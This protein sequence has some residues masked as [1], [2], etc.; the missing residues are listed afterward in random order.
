MAVGTKVVVEIIIMAKSFAFGALRVVVIAARIANI[1]VIA[2][3][4][5]SERNFIGEEIFVALVAQ[6]VLLVK[7]MRAN[8]GTVVDKG[9]LVSIKIFLTMLAK[10]I[11]LVQAVVADVN[12][13]AVT[14]DNLPRL[15]AKVLALLAEF[16]FIRVAVVA[17]E[18]VGKFA[19]TRN[20]QPVSPDLENLE[21]IGMV[22]TNGNFGVEFGMKPVDVTAKAV[23]AHDLDSVFVAAV[24][25]GL[26]EIGNAF[27]LGNFALNQIAI[28][29]RFGLS[30]AS[31]AV[32]V[33]EP[34]LK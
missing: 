26:P 6:Q 9:H 1:D 32:S 8:I 7:A 34:T 14:I 22:L 29:F 25:F 19:G 2:I 15:G 31:S 28:K 18:P 30:P 33:V 11:V 20:A 24:F 17:D 12:A 23:A 27:K 21:V 5:N 4:I 3:R 13:L 10:A 16:F